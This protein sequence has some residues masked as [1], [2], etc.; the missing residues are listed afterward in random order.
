MELK[1]EN[2]AAPDLPRCKDDYDYDYDDEN[3]KFHPV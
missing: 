1:F 3:D 2:L